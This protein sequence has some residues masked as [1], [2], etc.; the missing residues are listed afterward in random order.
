MIDDPKKQI[1]DPSMAL[2]RQLVTEYIIFPLG[3]KLIRNRHPDHCRSFLF[4]GPQ[5]TGKTQMVYAVAN[6]TK[7]VVY[8]LSPANIDGVLNTDKK[9]TD[10]MLAMVFLSAKEFQPALVY[11][12][13]A[14][15][16]WKA[17]KKG[18]KK[19]KKGG[20]NVKPMD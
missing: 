8:D 4:Y 9:E 7:S 20:A 11:V 18:K 6:E 3:S 12:D 16:V 1:K 13:E 14:E 19:G 2:I 15:K 5:G 10:K 17:K